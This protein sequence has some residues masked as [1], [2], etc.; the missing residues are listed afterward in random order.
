MLLMFSHRRNSATAFP[1]SIQAQFG[2]QL[3]V[4]TRPDAGTRKGKVRSRTETK[5]AKTR[6]TAT[7]V[8]QSRSSGKET[9]KN[10]KPA[11]DMSETV[12]VRF[13]QFRSFPRAMAS[14]LERSSWR[15]VGFLHGC[16]P[17]SIGTVIR[18]K[19]DDAC[20]LKPLPRER[21]KCRNGHN[22]RVTHLLEPGN[23]LA[24][25]KLRGILS[26][27]TKNGQLAHTFWKNA[28]CR[29]TRN[30]HDN[31]HQRRSDTAR[32]A[33]ERNDG[34][35]RTVREQP[36]NRRGSTPDTRNWNTSLRKRH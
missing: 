28:K 20:D 21:E 12:S 2:S 35:D 30:A 33:K 10:W 34:H 13:Q 36:K 24:R 8:T 26:G 16:P 22:Q 23:V 3:P 1:L 29:K 9:V 19:H 32:N 31:T 14:R 11:D 4:C 17:L 6:R 7:V 27:I 25:G 15:A 18:R 5:Y